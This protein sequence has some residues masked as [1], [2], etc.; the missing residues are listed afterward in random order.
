MPIIVLI[1]CSFLVARWARRKQ[2]SIMLWVVILWVSCITTALAVLA[3][4]DFNK[5][6]GYIGMAVGALPV[7][8]AVNQNLPDKQR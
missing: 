3:L 7:L 4:S 2:R 5:T 8:I 1:A 6:L